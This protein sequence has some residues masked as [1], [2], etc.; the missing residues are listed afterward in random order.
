M[1]PQGV[2]VKKKSSA[3]L[4]LVIAVYSPD[5]TRTTSCSLS[6]YVTINMLDQLK[7]MPGV[8]DATACCRPQDYAMRIWFRP[9]ADRP[10]PDPDDIIDAIQAQNIQA[11]V[12]RIGAQPIAD[13][14]QLQLNI[15]TQG[16]LTTVEEFEN[17]VVRA[18]PDGSVVRVRDV[19]RRRARRARS[20]TATRGSTARRRR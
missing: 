10:R 5:K 1:R 14:Q 2:T 12:G 6:N 17:I 19:A 7:R 15:Q 3:L 8:G 16:R 20:R 18:N 9:T 4:Q 11:A 13:D